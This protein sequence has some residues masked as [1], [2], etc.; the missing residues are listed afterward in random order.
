MIRM[1]TRQCE[2]QTTTLW[3]PEGGIATV[4]MPTYR[5]LSDRMLQVT[6]PAYRR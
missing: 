1:P 4:D 2:L 5:R 3:V 6:G